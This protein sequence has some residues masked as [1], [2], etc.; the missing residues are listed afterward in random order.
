VLPIP[1]D[2]SVFKAFL[3]IAYGARWMKANKKIV[4]D[5]LSPPAA[6]DGAA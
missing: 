2:E 6:L 5:P 3:H 4:G 1:V